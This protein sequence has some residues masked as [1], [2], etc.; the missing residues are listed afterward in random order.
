MPNLVGT[1]RRTASIARIVSE[2]E[3][4][5]RFCES[6]PRPFLSVFGGVRVTPESWHWRVTHELCAQ[7]G[8][9]GWNTASGGDSG[10]MRAALDGALESGSAAIAVRLNV[11]DEPHLCEYPH[12]ITLVELGP[13]KW[14]LEQANAYCFVGGGLGTLDEL[15]Q[16]LAQ[17][18]TGKTT[19]RPMVCLGGAFWR[20]FFSTLHRQCV[21][22]N[23]YL[24]DSFLAEH[25]VVVDSAAEAAEVIAQR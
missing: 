9:R 1:D 20:P 6:L 22:E 17:L 14:A 13:R 24:D 5:A 16:I 10:A 12:D 4:A 25:V 3:E 11:D 7:L 19:P 23:S 21:R 18:K 2:F 15:T 8:K